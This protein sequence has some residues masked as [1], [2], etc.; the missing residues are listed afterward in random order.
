MKTK[1]HYKKVADRLKD[2]SSRPVGKAGG[3]CHDTNGP[4][5][6]EPDPYVEQR[7]IGHCSRESRRFTLD[8]IGEHAHH[9][10]FPQAALD[11]VF[12]TV[13]HFLVVLFGFIG[14]AAFHVAGI[15]AGEPSL[16]PRGRCGTGLHAL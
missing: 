6:S 16:R 1:Q 11:F 2:E 13:S 5:W 3:G 14:D 7:L 10:L 12:Q 9:Q 15:V 4:S 8:Q